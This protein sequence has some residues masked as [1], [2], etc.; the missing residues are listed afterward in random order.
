MITLILSPAIKN[1]LT[2]TGNKVPLEN[3]KL[4]LSFQLNVK[5]EN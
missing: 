2:I 5:E 3:Q 1:H 4:Y